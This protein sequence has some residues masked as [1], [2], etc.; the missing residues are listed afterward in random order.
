MNGKESAAQQSAK[1]QHSRAYS[2]PHSAPTG[3]SRPGVG[4]VESRPQTRSW[5]SRLEEQ[6][7]RVR[8]GMRKCQ[9]PK[10]SFAFHCTLA[11]FWQCTE[12]MDSN[13]DFMSKARM[14]ICDTMGHPPSKVG[15]G[16]NGCRHLC[17]GANSLSNCFLRTSS[18]PTFDVYQ[19]NFM[20]VQV[21]ENHFFARETRVGAELHG[22]FQCGGLHTPAT[23]V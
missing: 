1:A 12:S 21:Q 6:A 2:Y 13:T 8:C 19:R 23:R 17:L 9:R 11:L 14:H 22:R 18:K 5:W 7:E 16:C 20:L 4:R 10:L 15:T 3:R